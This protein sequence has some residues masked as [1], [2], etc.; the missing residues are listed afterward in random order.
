MANKFRTTLPFNG[1]RLKLVA[2][3]IRKYALAVSMIRDF[4]YD[5]STT[6]VHHHHHHHHHRQ[7][8]GLMAG[9]D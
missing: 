4:S 1:L 8:L 7:G 3:S 6:V 9:S 5:V 2:K